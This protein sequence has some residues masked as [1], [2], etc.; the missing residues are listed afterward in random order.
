MPNFSTAAARA[1]LTSPSPRH[2]AGRIAL[3]TLQI[4]LACALLA[5]GGSK[6][7]GALPMVQLFDAIGVGQW[8]RY[9]TGTI[10]VAGA[11]L[12]L[13]PALSGVGAVLLSAVMVGA[14]MTHLFIVPS[15]PAAPLV[16]LAGLMTVAFVRRG[17]IAAQLGRA[18][19]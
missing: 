16:L 2:S 8:F 5:A 3:W 14:V 15:S 6:L 11:V 4:L 12:L 9:A 7:A 17:E 1:P 18:R 19:A 10:E 13:I